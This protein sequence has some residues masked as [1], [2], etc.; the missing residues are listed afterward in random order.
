M[1]A[2]IQANGWNVNGV[3]RFR[4]KQLETVIGVDRN[5]GELMAVL[6]RTR[7]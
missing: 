1:P 6:R 5:I 3:D 2:Y 4:R 7:W